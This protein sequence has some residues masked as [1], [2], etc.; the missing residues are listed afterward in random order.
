MHQSVFKALLSARPLK[1]QSRRPWSHQLIISADDVGECCFS[2][3]GPQCRLLMS[4][5]KGKISCRS[6]LP[7]FERAHYLRLCGVELQPSTTTGEDALHT[8]SLTH[9]DHLPGK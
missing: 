8:H 9:A 6:F 4:G 1:M 3:P 5:W 7:K 2:S